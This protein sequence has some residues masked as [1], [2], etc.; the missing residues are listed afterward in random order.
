MVLAAV[1]VPAKMAN[2]NAWASISPHSM[3]NQC[4]LELTAENRHAQVE[5]TRNLAQIGKK[6]CTGRGIARYK[7]IRGPSACAKKALVEK[8]VNLKPVRAGARTMVV[9]SFNLNAKNVIIA[10]HV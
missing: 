10:E 4:G 7:T 8:A 5:S 6:C 3:T 9:I 1:M 2:V